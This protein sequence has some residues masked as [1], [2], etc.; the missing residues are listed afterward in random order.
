LRIDPDRCIRCYCCY[1]FCTYG[2]IRIGRPFDRVLKR[3]VRLKEG[4]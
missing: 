4:L 3:L 1:E 2:A